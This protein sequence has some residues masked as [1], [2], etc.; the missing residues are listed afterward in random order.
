[1]RHGALRE[2][3]GY[4]HGILTVHELPLL[5]GAGPLVACCLWSGGL[6]RRLR[7]VTRVRTLCT[8]CESGHV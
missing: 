7:I 8:G 3:V 5:Q 2:R 1:M 6:G 4:G